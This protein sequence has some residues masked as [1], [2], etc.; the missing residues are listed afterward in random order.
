[1]AELEFDYELTLSQNYDNTCLGNEPDGQIFQF[2]IAD[3][4]QVNDKT[5]PVLADYSALTWEYFAALMTQ[6]AISRIGIKNFPQVGACGFYVDKYTLQTVIFTPI[7]AAEQT[8]D[9]PTIAISEV[10]E[11][12][13]VTITPPE[14]ITYTCYKVIM[15]SGYYANEFVMYETTAVLTKPAVIGT[16]DVFAIGY[17]EDTGIMSSWSN[18]ETLTISSG[19]ANWEPSALTVPM[20]LADLV[21]VN[22]V[23]LLNAQSLRYNSVS[24]KWEN[25]NTGDVL[26]ATLLV[27]NWTGSAVPYTQTISLTGILASGYSYVVTPDDDSWE[28]Y[29]AAGIYMDD[30]DTDGS[31]TFNATSAMPAVALTVNILKVRAT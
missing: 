3:E 19:N 28:A 30:P 6:R 8:Y 18:V 24:G 7:S 10:S 15:R 17:N 11:G 16:Y 12:I 14:G 21:D 27:T 5:T 29:A 20:S 4:H 26:T 1:V 23:D 2:G 9:P 22:L 31:V 13:S 25:A